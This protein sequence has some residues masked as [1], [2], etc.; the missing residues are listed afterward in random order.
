MGIK[1]DYDIY[2]RRSIPKAIKNPFCNGQLP[3]RTTASCGSKANLKAKP[4]VSLLT[5]CQTFA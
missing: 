3:G 1:G 2:H 4:G 5:F